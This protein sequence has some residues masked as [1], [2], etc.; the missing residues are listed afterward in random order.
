MAEWQLL[1][2]AEAVA[3]A[4]C[5]AIAAAAQDA[6]RAR[7]SFSL[8]LAGG[9][10]PQR[11]YRLLAGTEQQWAHWQLFYGDERCLPAGHADRNS[12]MVVE[13]GLAARAGSHFEIPAEL[14]AEK[15]AALY[16][17]RIE[18]FMPFDMVLLGMGEDG[19]TASL[20]PGQDWPQQAVIPVHNAPKPPAD[21]VSLNVGALQTAQSML[22]MVTGASKRNAVKAWR[23]GAD[24][25]INMVSDVP[26]AMVLVESSLLE[27]DQ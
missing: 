2:N 15:A 5:D 13:S 6:I 4:A 12:Q 23:E 14:G 22:V 3:R 8:V 19:H 17:S 11:A 21:R 26:R 1:E 16:Q 10:T 20:F 18:S 25:P 24:L 9:T 27:H 7:G